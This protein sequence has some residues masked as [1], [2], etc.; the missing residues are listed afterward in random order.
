MPE[1]KPSDLVRNY[2]RDHYVS[3]ARTGIAFSIRAGDVHQALEFANRMPVVCSVLGS[4]RFCLDNNL[5]RLSTE[6]PLN[7][8]NAIFKFKRL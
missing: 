4:N 3:R 8:A 7:G 6:G 1:R 2:C 5:V